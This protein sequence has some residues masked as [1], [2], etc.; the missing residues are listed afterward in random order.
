MSRSYSYGCTGF[1]SADRA[2]KLVWQFNRDSFIIMLLKKK[3]KIECC[4]TYSQQ[5]YI[6]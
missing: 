1:L 4:Q 6:N 2:L 5:Y 3:I